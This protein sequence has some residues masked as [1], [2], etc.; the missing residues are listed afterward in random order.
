MTIRNI[1]GFETGSLTEAN[2]SSGTV[3]IDSTTKRTGNYSL[4]CNPAGNATGFVFLKTF[5]ATSGAQTELNDATSYTRFY[6]NPA[7][8]PAANSEEIAQIQ[9]WAMYA[10][11]M[12]VRITSAGKLQV[13]SNDGTTQLG[14]DG[15]TVLS[16]GTWYRIEIKCG[17]GA[18]ATVPYEVKINGASELSGTGTLGTSNTGRVG[19]GKVT[20]RNGQT[21]DF[22]Y[23]DVQINSAAYPGAGAVMRLDPDGDGAYTAWTIGAGAGSDWENVDEVPYD[24]DTTYLQSTLT[25]GQAST[26]SLES[27]ASA[28][29]SG[30]ISGVLAG[31]YC[32]RD[33]GVPWVKFRI[34]SSTTNKDVSSSINPGSAYAYY[35]VISETDPATSDVWSTSGLDGA[36]IGCVED[37]TAN[38]TR[39]TAGYLMVD[40][41]AS[42]GYTLDLSAAS[43]VLTGINITTAVA[44]FLNTDVGV[45]TLSGVNIEA[46]AGRIMATSV[47]AFTLSGI[48]IDLFR[49]YSLGFAPGVFTLTG[50]D[51]SGLTAGRRIDASKGTFLLNGMDIGL[52]KGTAPTPVTGGG[53]PLWM[54][55]MMKQRELRKRLD[56]EEIILLVYEW[57]RWNG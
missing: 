19:I 2:S 11:K 38:Y 23:D 5:D 51:L 22:Y 17:T 25:V 46:L 14:S 33:A 34:R 13:Y 57:M 53:F 16:A 55:Y 35:G 49:G 24:S 26:V 50:I 45:F 47:G 3:S 56:E 30:T 32:K 15:A 10:V 28:G 6:F 43:F 44:R 20:N 9:D 40:F 27:C 41:L 52:T 4:R 18:G 21:V 8:L 1:C 39:W 54:L 42:T 29:V 36:Q 12:T 37:G 7:T 31:F 48:N